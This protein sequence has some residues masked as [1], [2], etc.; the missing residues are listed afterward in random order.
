MTSEMISI[1]H[2]V[3]E[4]GAD[5]CVQLPVALLVP[6]HDVRAACERNRCNGFGRNYM[7]PPFI[8]TFREI[9]ERLSKFSHG[10]LFQQAHTVTDKNDRVVVQQTQQAS[11]DLV[12]RVEQ[13]LESR[14]N[15][16]HW[17]MP[18]GQCIVC[19][20]CR[21]ETGQPCAFPDRARNSL[22]AIGISVMSLNESLGLHHQ[23]QPG[24]IVWTAAVLW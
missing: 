4:M 11:Y 18:G 20:P 13:Y 7:C 21:A 10:I 12:I 3:H 24:K 1:L 15:C 22:E 23:F 6:D 16:D 5:R 8:G 17:G 19:S 14:G 2:D 9:R